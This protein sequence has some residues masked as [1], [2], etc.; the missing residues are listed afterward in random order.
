MKVIENHFGGANVSTDI[1][2]WLPEDAPPHL[3]AFQ[4]CVTVFHWENL[5]SNPD[6]EPEP[7]IRVGTWVLF[8]HEAQDLIEALKKA[9]ELT[10]DKQSA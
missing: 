6:T 2:P 5:L 1:Y 3:I 8:P 7:P 10:S 4:G 9:V